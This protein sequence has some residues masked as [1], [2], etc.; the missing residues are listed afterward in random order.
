MNTQLIYLK[1]EHISETELQKAVKILQEDQCVAI[2]TETVYG[3]AANAL[4]ESAIKRI[5]EAKGR[6]SDNPLIVHVSNMDMLKRCIQQDLSNRITAIINAFW[7]GPLTLVFKKSTLIPDVVSAHLDTVG[8]RWPAHPIALALIEAS[9]FPLA[10]PSANVSGRPSPTKA[11][12]VLHDLNGKIAGII[13]AEQSVVGVESTVLDVSCEDFKVLRKGGVS[14]ESLRSIDPLISYD[15]ALAHPELTPKSPGQKYKHY[16]P[17]KPMLALSGNIESLVHHLQTMDLSQ[18]LLIS[19]DEILDQLNTPYQLTLG[20]YDNH[21]VAM[22]RLFDCL[23]ASESM[24]V[25]AIVITGFE[26]VGLGATLN[27]RIGKA[28][29]Q[30]LTII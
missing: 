22:N 25:D 9:G 27:D 4:S 18:T 3:L 14:L 11:E 30:K 12:H 16:A 2:P 10:A 29:S 28:S 23:R 13:M 1:T 21:E 19:V 8:I 15:D 17:S 5:F 6:P 26:D 7:P 24:P 20:S